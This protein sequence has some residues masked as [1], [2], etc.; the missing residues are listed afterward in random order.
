MSIF[1]YVLA[2]TLFGQTNVNMD[3][4]T[5][6]ELEN[7]HS[8]IMS[9]DIELITGG[10]MIDSSRMA[11][12]YTLPDGRIAVIGIT[13]SPG[14]KGIIFNNYA[15]FM[16]HL[17]RGKLPV[18]NPEKV[19]WED[20]QSEFLSTNDP[21]EFFASYI[22]ERSS[23]DVHDPDKEKFSAVYN[24]F[25]DEYHKGKTTAKDAVALF[26]VGAEIYRRQFNGKWLLIEESGV[27]NPF[28]TLSI[29]LE[30]GE[31]VEL[32]FFILNHF[33]KGLKFNDPYFRNFMNA[34][35]FFNLTD[36]SKMGIHYIIL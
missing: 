15:C 32:D 26:V 4:Y 35:S 19:F 8:L 2:I 34:Q 12:A 27:Y 28:Y 20:L 30:S 6:D 13:L 25:L 9:Y 24:Y 22:Q 3:C 36:L 11:K 17:K 16:E 29:L 1:S 23:Y 33:S 31:V 5:L 10:E 21:F 14:A 18:E 7:I